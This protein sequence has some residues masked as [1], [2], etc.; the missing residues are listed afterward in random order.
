[1][2]KSEAH[3]P[4]LKGLT[5]LHLDVCV[6]LLSGANANAVAGGSEGG[7]GAAAEGHHRREEETH[8][9]LTPLRPSGP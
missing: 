5:F 3:Q 7:G 4:N 2:L 6:K 8:G 1:M 9:G